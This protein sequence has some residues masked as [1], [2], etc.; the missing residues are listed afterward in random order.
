MRRLR[1]ETARYAR[2]TTPGISFESFIIP[3]EADGQ[4]LIS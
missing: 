4:A 1:K 3:P 2:S